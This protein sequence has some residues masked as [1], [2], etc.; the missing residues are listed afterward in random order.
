MATRHVQFVSLIIAITGWKS[1][2]ITFN[3]P[4]QIAA[5]KTN[6][7]HTSWREQFKGA[8]QAIAHVARQQEVALMGE[9]EQSLN[10]KLQQQENAP[11][12]PRMLNMSTTHTT[13]VL[14]SFLYSTARDA[15]ALV[16]SPKVLITRTG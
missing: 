14:V 7:A 6:A 13:V 8:R 1:A 11:A 4:A 10:T 9:V 5:I 2:L 12:R 16:L 15:I 3:D